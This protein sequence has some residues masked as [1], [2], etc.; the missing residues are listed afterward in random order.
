MTC[1]VIKEIHIAPVEISCEE[2][3]LILLF[4]DNAS[5][6]VALIALAYFILT[7]VFKEGM[8]WDDI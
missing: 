2:Y 1:T 5:K 4:N 3:N 7:E 8:G 6:D